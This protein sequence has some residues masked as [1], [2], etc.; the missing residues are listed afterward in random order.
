MVRLLD[1]L[2]WVPY[3]AYRR[4]RK[5]IVL[6]ETGEPLNAWVYIARSPRKH[7]AAS[8]EYK[9]KILQACKKYGFPESY[10][11]HVPQLDSKEK[12]KIDPYFFL[13]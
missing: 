4:V 2:E 1:I 12:F 5:S 8:V 10:Y 9:N 7:L 13:L 3:G 11:E 6:K